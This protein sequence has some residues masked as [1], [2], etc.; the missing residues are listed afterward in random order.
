MN[1][2][3]AGIGANLTFGVLSS[4]AATTRGVVDMIGTIKQS[5]GPDIKKAIDELDLE[6]TLKI[7]HCLVSEIQIDDRT[8]ET[9]H[10]CLKSLMDVVRLIYDE[11]GRI[12]YRLQYNNSL[13]VGKTFRSY[14]F[15]NCES[16]LRTY[17]IVL[18][19]RK[20]LLIDI[21]NMQDRMVRNQN[22]FTPYIPNSCSKNIDM[23][24]PE[25]K[26]LF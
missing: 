7:I 9:I 2:L 15:I 20:K 6:T 21:I 4:F 25:N 22:I 13:W 18:E 23:V 3:I 16:R 24:T 14:R 17:M 19:N 10:V 1:L 26:R 8:P 12:N 5:C 11:L